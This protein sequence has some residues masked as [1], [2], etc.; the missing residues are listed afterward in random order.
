[1]RRRYLLQVIPGWKASFVGGIRQSQWSQRRCSE[2]SQPNRA[3]PANSVI[4]CYWFSIGGE[5][6]SFS[7]HYSRPASANID[8][9]STFLRKTNKNA[10]NKIRYRLLNSDG[11]SNIV[12]RFAAPVS[13][14]RPR[15]RRL[16]QRTLADSKNTRCRH[17]SS[18]VLLTKTWRS[19]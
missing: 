15:R 6:W 9:G 4:D 10:E 2:S 13:V 16:R 12:S 7:S 19:C 14:F 11:K 5:R 1:M 8:T 3:K 17:F 18:S